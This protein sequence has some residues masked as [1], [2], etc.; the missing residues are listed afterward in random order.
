MSTVAVMSYCK[1][2][3]DGL[4]IPAGAGTGP[5]IA[6][7]VPPDPDDNPNGQPCCSIWDT[8]GDESRLAASRQTV[9][10]ANPSPV[11]IDQAAPEPGAGRK[12]QW[13][14]LSFYLWYPMADEETAEDIAF[15]A[16]IDAVM[17]ALRTTPDPVVL[18]DPLT[19]AISQLAGLGENMRR[20]MSPP[21]ALSPQ[22]WEKFVGLITSKALEEFDA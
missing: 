22:R 3:L 15:P 1:S 19:G 9:A 6:Y 4:V 20:Q 2:V 11:V 14:E 13:H 17:T 10:L 16:V 12:I 21:L 18:K 7:I 5:L 8:A